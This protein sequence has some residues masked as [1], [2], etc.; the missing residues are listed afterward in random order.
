MTEISDKSWMASSDTALMAILGAFIKHH[1]LLQ[2]K[3]QGQ[4]AQ[5]AGI[6]RSTLS[7]FEKGENTSLIVF[8]QLLR[9]LKL[10]H[11]LQAFQFRHQISPLQLA[12]LEKSQRIRASRATKKDTKPKSDW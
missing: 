9:A 6:V 2:N 10:L 12:K 4:L 3:T 11:L 1:R 8:I 7:L 5:E